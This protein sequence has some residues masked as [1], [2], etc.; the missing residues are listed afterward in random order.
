VIVLHHLGEDVEG[1]GSGEV[2]VGLRD[3]GGELDCPV[4]AKHLFESDL[5]GNVVLIE[6]GEQLLGA[7]H[8]RDL[9]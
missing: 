9:L 5:E 3:E 1:V 7:E 6:V 4:V 8:T 2:G